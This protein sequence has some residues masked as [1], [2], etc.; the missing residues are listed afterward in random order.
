MDIDDACRALVAVRGDA[1]IV[2][3]MGAMGALDRLEVGQPRLSCVP[4]MGGA[5]S[6]GLGI[7]LQRPR[8]TI[9]VLDGD[10]SLLM[11]LGGLVTV[12]GAKPRNFHHFVMENGVQFAGMSNLPLASSMLDL[13]AM[14]AAAGYVSCSSH[15]DVESLTAALQGLLSRPGPS[16][17]SLRITPPPA[18]FKQGAPQRALPDW[19]F[20]RMGEEARALQ[21][22]LRHRPL[23]AAA[24]S[25]PRRE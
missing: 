14:A 4:L 11:E 21:A 3:T 15:G 20:Q 19:H 12:A 22:W 23:A 9:V 5:A 7:A 8:E 25:A 24:P 18:S 10:A 16:F 6:L 13:C 2:A 1:I 17:T